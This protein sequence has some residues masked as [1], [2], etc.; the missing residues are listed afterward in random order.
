MILRGIRAESDT[1]AELLKIAAVGDIIEICEMTG[2]DPNWS[3]HPDGVVI[4]RDRKLLLNGTQEL[5]VL[6]VDVGEWDVATDGSIIVRKDNSFYRLDGRLICT[7]E[8]LVSK[9]AIHSDGIVAETENGYVSLNNKTAL[10]QG[11]SEDWAVADDETLLIL[12]HD[13]EIF[14]ANGDRL[15]KYTGAQYLLPFKGG[16]LVVAEDDFMI[17]NGA[18]ILLTTVWDGCDTNANGL[19]IW[20]DNKIFLHVFNK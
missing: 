13:G 3:G 5:A 10:Y 12:N 9:W 19:Y 18:T 6:A 7:F 17:D 16:A 1:F 4:E 11:K 14:R 2:L 20:R 8:S 15:S